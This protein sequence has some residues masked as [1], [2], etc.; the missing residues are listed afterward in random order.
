MFPGGV[1]AGTIA[2][3]DDPITCESIHGF[4]Y[5]TFLA[6]DCTCEGTVKDGGIEKK[7]KHSI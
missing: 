6:I 5:G 4:F 3:C 7:S 2:P 1:G